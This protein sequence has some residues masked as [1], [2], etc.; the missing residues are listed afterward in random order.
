MFALRRVCHQPPR[1]W[2][3]TI[4]TLPPLPPYNEW[5]NIFP[6]VGYSDRVT[7]RDEALADKL[8]NAFL[9]DDKHSG[10]PNEGKIVIEAFPGVCCR[11]VVLQS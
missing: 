2:R 5:K 10:N 6:Y 3:R 1:I 9:E 7:I 8:A 4:S 11:K